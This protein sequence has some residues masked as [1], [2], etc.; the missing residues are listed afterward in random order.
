MWRFDHTR[1]V[2]QVRSGCPAE[3]VRHIIGV[4]ERNEARAYDDA[5]MKRV[6]ELLAGLRKD[7]AGFPPAPEP[8]CPGTIRWRP[9]GTGTELIN[10]D[11]DE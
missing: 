4:L 7:R 3:E 6:D 8:F 9:P 2:G 11:D 10:R 1:L 5:A